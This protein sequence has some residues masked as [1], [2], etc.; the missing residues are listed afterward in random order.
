ME[1]TIEGKIE[2]ILQLEERGENNDFLIQKVILTVDK[3]YTKKNG[4]V[5]TREQPIQVEFKGKQVALFNGFKL[6]DKVDVAFN[7]NGAKWQ[8]DNMEN[9]KYF[10]SLEAW[11]ITKVLPDSNPLVDDAPAFTAASILDDPF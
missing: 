2:N 6:G 8:N 5:V 3:S 7:I 10:T 9:P 1:Y 4:E 11:R